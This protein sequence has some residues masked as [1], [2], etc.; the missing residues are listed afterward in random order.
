MEINFEHIG[1][2]LGTRV[3][4][5]NVR[6]EIEKSLKSGSFVTFNF[7]NVRLVSHSF[8]DEC[9][10]KLLMT[11]SI[12]DLKANTTFVG[13]NSVIKKTIAF[14]LEERANNLELV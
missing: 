7:N 11:W 3:L 13:A 6:L 2:S 12:A 14:T 8:A 9:F 5:K 4:A 1:S 10:G